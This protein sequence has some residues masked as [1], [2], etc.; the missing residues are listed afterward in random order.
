VQPPSP[1]IPTPVI[2][3]AVVERGDKIIVTFTTPPRTVD[4]VAV[5]KFS[6]IDLSVGAADKAPQ[7]NKI[8]SVEV[9]PASDKEDPQPKPVEYSLDASEYIGQLISA[10]VRTAMKKNG[11]YSE[12]SKKAVIAVIPPLEKPV[13]SWQPS[14]AGIVLTWPLSTAAQYQ[15]QRQGQSDKQPVAIASVNENNYVDSSAAYDTDYRYIVTA[16]KSS[17]E[18]TPSEPI[19]AN[20]PDI[21]PPT[22]PSGLTAL[23][24]PD[25]IELAWQRSPESDLQGYYVYRSINGGPFQ[26]VGDLVNV[27]T[28][29]DRS[30]EHGKTYSYKISAIDKKGNTSAQSN[31]VEAQF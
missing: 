20:F 7:D 25:S 1:E 13:V 18:S 3:V 12:W 23:V 19:T 29:T 22:V 4:G 17:A 10:S 9:P 27:P 21:Y 6:H 26:R 2:D 28:Y 5:T 31:A 8:I 30:V 11:H 15:V 16:K 14:A 24:G